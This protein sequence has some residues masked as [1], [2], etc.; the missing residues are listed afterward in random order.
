MKY[1]D[2]EAQRVF[3]FPLEHVD[4][5]WTAFFRGNKCIEMTMFS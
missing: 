2:S 1:F 3:I 4:T 5:F